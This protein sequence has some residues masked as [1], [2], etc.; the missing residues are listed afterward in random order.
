MIN[1]QKILGIV[2]GASLAFA[3]AAP[4]S[5][6]S[7]Q[8]EL[9]KVTFRDAV[10][11][12]GHVLAPGSYYF[13]RIDNGNDPDINLLEISSVGSDSTRIFIQTEPVDREH[14][15]I[16]TVL[17]FAAGSKGMPPALLDWFYPGEQTGHMFVYSQ[18]RE[19]QIEA[20]KE[21][22][23]ASSPSGVTPVNHASWMYND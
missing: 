4:V 7:E 2:A 21:F 1:L 5:R 10:R 23:L 17:T 22:T 15:S 18:P 16:N 12:P 20:A 11:I 6:A 19:K 3:I 8:S 13:T 14:T 9:T